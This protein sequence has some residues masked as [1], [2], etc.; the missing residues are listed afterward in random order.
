MPISGPAIES[1]FEFETLTRGFIVSAPR[2]DMAQYDRVIDTKKKL[3]RVQIKG[4]RG[5]GRKSFVVRIGKSNERP[6]T[7]QDADILALYIE[8]N[9]AWYI[10]PIE[11]VRYVFKMNIGND[12]LIKYKDN[13]KLFK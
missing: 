3:Y 13:W 10:I 1:L 5:K 7:K 6:Y 4:R 8:D 2:S 12:T 9:N 11:E